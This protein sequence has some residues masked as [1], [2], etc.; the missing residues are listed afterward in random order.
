M[1][2]GTMRP[3]GHAGIYSVAVSCLRRTGLVAGLALAACT[4][5]PGLGNFGADVTRSTA[6]YAMGQVDRLWTSAPGALTLVQRADAVEGIQLI[7]LENATSLSGDNL[8]WLRAYKGRNSGR[9][10][11]EGLIGRVGGVPAPFQSLDNR[12]LRNGTDTL[13][14]YFWQEWRSGGQ[15][16]CVIAFRRLESAARALPRGKNTL[17]VFLRNCVV[18]SM[19]MA[20]APIRDTNIRAGTTGRTSAATVGGRILSPLAAPR[21]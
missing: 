20:L 16:N 8:L 1:T 2:R 9:F 6:Q 13:G 21:N 10:D 17:E 7:G 15:T 19:D 12:N 14:P 11:L 4:T 5:A 18:G 3:S